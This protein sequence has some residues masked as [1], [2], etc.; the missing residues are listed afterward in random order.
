MAKQA[1]KSFMTWLKS[2]MDKRDWGITVTARKAGLTHPVISDI[3]N[4][5]VQP[6]FET[7]VALA[8]AFRVPPDEVMRMA[9]L[10]PG[11]DLDIDDEDLQKIIDTYKYL[12]QEERKDIVAYALMR[13]QRASEIEKSS[14]RK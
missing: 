2:E 3:L 9:S 4:L 13:Y 10:L 7:C 14:K 11:T 12:S 1:S 5:Q 8:N 6:T